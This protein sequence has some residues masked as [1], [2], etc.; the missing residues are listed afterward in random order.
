MTR[1]E[2]MAAVRA[3]PQDARAWLALGRVLA[4][5]GEKAK[6][7]DSYQ[8]ALQIAPDFEEAQAALAGLDGSPGKVVLPPWLEEGE[9]IEVDLAPRTAPPPRLSN[10]TA[11]PSPLPPF[12][13]SVEEPGAL[14]NEP[15][16]VEDGA[17]LATPLAAEAA[18]PRRADEAGRFQFTAMVLAVALLMCGVLAAFLAREEPLKHWEAKEAVEALKQGGVPI[19]H[20]SYLGRGDLSGDGTFSEVSRALQGATGNKPVPTKEP[21][22]D[23]VAEVAMVML[24]RS[25]CQE[26]FCYIEVVA[27]DSRLHLEIARALGGGGV[28]AK[29]NLLVILQGQVTPEVEQHYWQALAALK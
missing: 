24:P 22:D 2:A 27:F 15:W 4:A 23:A 5:E 6:A 26:F 21:Y 16:R 20:V 12:L 29:G 9:A 11:T 14:G 7:R 17:H 19:Q 10:R 3:Q 8:R 1:S 25:A 18:V 28:S 13:Q